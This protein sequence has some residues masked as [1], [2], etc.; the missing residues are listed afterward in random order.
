[1]SAQVA[2]V[3]LNRAIAKLGEQRFLSV[4]E[5]A[6]YV[7]KHP[8]TVRRA[9]RS[10]EMHGSQ[11]GQKGNTWTVRPECADAWLDGDPCEHQDADRRPIS[12]QEHRL[13]AVGGRP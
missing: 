10:G 6:L 13:R 9:L 3:E 11:R 12:L 7:G 1:M 2:Q 8:E 4:M 5:A